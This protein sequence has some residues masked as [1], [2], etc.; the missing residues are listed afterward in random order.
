MR[1]TFRS[2]M[3]KELTVKELELYIVTTQGFINIKNI[4]FF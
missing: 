3:K 2:A 1:T 4:D